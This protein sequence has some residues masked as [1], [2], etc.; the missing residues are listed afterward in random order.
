MATASQCA[1]F[2]NT[3]AAETGLI[4]ALAQQRIM[5]HSSIPFKVVKETDYDFRAGESPTWIRYRRG[6]APRQDYQ[7]FKQEGT[8]SRDWPT[9]DCAGDDDT[10]NSTAQ[11]TGANCEIVGPKVHIGYDEFGRCPKRSAVESEIICIIDVLEKKN[12]GEYIEMLRESLIFAAVENYSLNVRKDMVEFSHYKASVVANFSVGMTTG[13]THFPAKPEGMLSIG[14]LKRLRPLLIAEGYFE[15]AGTPSM[16]GQPTMRVY[17]GA[18]AIEQAIA[19]WKKIQGMV[20]M[21]EKLA[22]D[23][24]FGDTMVY[25][26]F[27]FIKDEM[28]QRG[29]LR[30]TDASTY[31]LVEIPPTIERAGAMGKVQIPNPD[32]YNCFINCNGSK[33]RVYEVGHITHPEGLERQRYEMPMIDE[34]FS[35]EGLRY[36]SFDV[37]FLNDAILYDGFDADDNRIVV[38]NEDKN[39]AKMKIGHAYAPFTKMPEKTASFIYMASPET[40]DVW[41]PGCNDDCPVDDESNIVAQDHLAQRTGPA[42]CTKTLEDPIIDPNNTCADPYPAG[43]AG[44]LNVQAV[45]IN[46]DYEGTSVRVCVERSGGHEGAAT[47]NLDYTNGTAIAGTH[48][49]DPGTVALSWLDGEMGVKCDDLVLT[50]ASPNVS[51]GLTINYTISGETGAALGSEDTGVIT[52]TSDPDC[53]SSPCDC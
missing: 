22:K 15:N 53:T 44:E 48:W 9:K 8:E 3:M 12:P 19:N 45:A 17:A 2:R 40:I 6:R 49:T 18:Q 46:A 13:V 21:S 34:M 5:S 31:E 23:P 20:I 51:A 41:Q 33:E 37:N 10:I 4:Q 30:K 26:G 7:Y 16:D 39:M 36:A 27:Q 1:E 52:L 38:Y 29:W 25:D 43:G 50:P 35:G 42:N 47:V 32:Y 11:K 28:P 24:T 14:L